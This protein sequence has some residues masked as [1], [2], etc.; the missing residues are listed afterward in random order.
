MRRY[1]SLC[2]A[3]I[4]VGVA[5]VLWRRGYLILGDPSIQFN[6]WSVAMYRN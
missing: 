5:M 2:L 4:P 3:R 1:L 6:V